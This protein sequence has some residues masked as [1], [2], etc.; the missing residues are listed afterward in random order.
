MCI[1]DRQQTD[2]S[3][4]NFTSTFLEQNRYESTDV[5]SNPGEYASRGGVLDVFSFS[6]KYPFRVGFLGGNTKALV[7]NPNSGDVVREETTARAF[8]F[9]QRPLYSIE[10]KI[11][12][13]KFI[14][15]CKKE[16]IIIKNTQVKSGTTLTLKNP[17]T[18]KPMVK[19]VS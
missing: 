6:S 10:E 15:F 17:I 13:H 14:V 4:R 18:T 2:K 19:E 5:V 1:R 16:R 9:P 11:K 7:F 8:P 3:L 12:Q